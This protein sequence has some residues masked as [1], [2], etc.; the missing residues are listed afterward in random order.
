MKKKQRVVENLNQALHSLFE[1]YDDVS[2]IGEDILDPYGGAFKVTRGLSTRFPDRVLSS[3]IS[4]E[5]IVGVANGLALCGERP[6]VEIM[7]G[8]FIALAFDPIVNF[9]GKSV[10][11]YG[12]EKPLSMVV[13]CTVGGNRGYGPTHSQSLQKHFV[14]VP[15]LELY[16]LTPFH[17]N[18]KVL[19]RLVNLGRPSIFFEDKTLYTQFMLTEPVID[20]LLSWEPLGGAGDWVSVGSPEFETDAWLI[21]APGGLA[22]RCLA[23]MRELFIDHEIES[24]L[25]VP[26]RLYPVDVET[27]GASVQRAGR[28]LVVEECTAGG[29]W[30]S[31]VSCRLYERYWSSITNRVELLSSKDS[32]IPSSAHLEREVIVQTEDIVRVMTG[33]KDHG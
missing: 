12:A 26:S 24:R 3:P 6:I 31:E 5:G 11:M 18:L 7:F 9:A 25:M 19:D 17:D 14:G 23:A 27:I 21:I 33:A 13:R 22:H 20:E 4:E 15:G 29:T 28:I 2:L 10:T 30:G 8:D 1:T 32:V 16:E